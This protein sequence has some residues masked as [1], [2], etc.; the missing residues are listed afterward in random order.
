[1]WEPK[2]DV[3]WTCQ[4]RS[5]EIGL[6]IYDGMNGFGY[7]IVLIGNALTLVVN[8]ANWSSNGEEKK[9]NLHSAST[10][11]SENILKNALWKD[12]PR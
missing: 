5:K 9:K 2:K 4:K 12:L 10:F 3:M 1:M 11:H 6:K 8:E 7:I